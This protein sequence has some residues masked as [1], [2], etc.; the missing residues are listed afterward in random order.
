VKSEVAAALSV[1]CVIFFIEDNP[2]GTATTALLI[3]LHW[4]LDALLADVVNISLT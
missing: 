4:S 1:M 2:E 3:W